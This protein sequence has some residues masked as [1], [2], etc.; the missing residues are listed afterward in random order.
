MK[1]T[2][3]L[4][5]LA[6]I[7]LSSAG[8]IGGS[9]S[10]PPGNEPPPA[11][12]ILDLNG[13]PIPGGG[14]GATFQQYS[15][16]F[17]ANV[18]NTAITFAFRDDP[19]FISFE[20]ASVTDLTSPGPNLLMD[21]DFSAGTYTN[22]GNSSTPIGWTYANQYGA[23]SGGDVA[24]GCG[25]PQPSGICWDDGAVNAYDAISQTI[26]TIIGH[27]YK[28][29]FYV[30]EDSGCGCNFSRLSGNDVS[31]IDVT[32]YAQS[33]LPAAGTT[34]TAA[35]APGSLWLLLA[36]AAF[37]AGCVYRDRFRQAVFGR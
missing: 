32:V 6:L 29:S 4:F 33:G 14:N 34:P 22:N 19:A 30:A 25:G 35:P 23:T 20:E 37:S 26:T 2:K 10:D 7:A 36:G 31:G 12:A 17:V 5:S 11:G 13:T 15:V 24:T 1:A 21:G 9:K 8:A 28:I 3:A 16:N 18:A 27:M